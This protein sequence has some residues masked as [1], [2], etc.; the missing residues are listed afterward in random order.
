MNPVS[1]VTSPDVSFVACGF[2]Q[3]SASKRSCCT[4]YLCQD[5]PDHD[6]KLYGLQRNKAGY[7]SHDALIN[8]FHLRGKHVGE[9]G[10]GS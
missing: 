8:A 4:A 2:L 1:G 9:E 6:D 3:P 10:N 5:L 7:T